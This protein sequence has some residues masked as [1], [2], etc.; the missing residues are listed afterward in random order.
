[1][2]CRGGLD[3]ERTG[4]L[5]KFTAS[6]SGPPPSSAPGTK[7]FSVQMSSGEASIASE[8]NLKWLLLR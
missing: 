3:Y 7:T 1:M 4:C 2:H 5:V 6:V 8:I